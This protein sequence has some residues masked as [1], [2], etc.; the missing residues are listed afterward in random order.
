MCGCLLS[1]WQWPYARPSTIGRAL[2][3]SGRLLTPEKQNLDVLNTFCGR[4]YGRLGVIQNPVHSLL[5]I[6]YNLYSHIHRYS[7]QCYMVYIETYRIDCIWSFFVW[8]RCS[9]V[10]RIL[11]MTIHM[12]MELIFYMTVTTAHHV[13]HQ[14]ILHMRMACLLRGSLMI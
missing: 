10:I 4:K 8:Y 14:T 6:K 2:W 13:N 12:N 11:T 3:N 7:S 5:N 9:V 1:F